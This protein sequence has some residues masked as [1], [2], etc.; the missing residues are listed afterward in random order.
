MVDEY[1]NY[2]RPGRRRRRR[3]APPEN[4]PEN[5]QEGG[6]IPAP[7][8]EEEP[9][10]LASHPALQ[11]SVVQREPADQPAPPAPALV[12]DAAPHVPRRARRPI[13]KR[14]LFLIAVNIP[15]SA[16]IGVLLAIPAFSTNDLLSAFAGMLLL[17]EALAF[18][19]LLKMLLQMTRQQTIR[20]SL[21]FRGSLAAALVALAVFIVASATAA[22]GQDG[23]PL[24]GVALMIWLESVLVLSVS[25]VTAVKKAK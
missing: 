16:G 6:L 5:I 9:P 20:N 7:A 4:I 2:R 13:D 15:L 23:G 8:Q 19:A 25:I 22:P 11:E 14:L 3:P 12:Q 21:L 24:A 10:E 17:G 1:A 18:I